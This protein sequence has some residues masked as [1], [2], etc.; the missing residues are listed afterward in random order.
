[1][2][3]RLSSI[4]SRRP[5]KVLDFRAVGSGVERMGISTSRS[6]YAC[7]EINKL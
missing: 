3:L 5:A 1:M 2:G 7:H 4:R 6:L